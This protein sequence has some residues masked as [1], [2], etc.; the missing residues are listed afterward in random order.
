M[1]DHHRSQRSPGCRTIRG[2][3]V[4]ATAALLATACK[5]GANASQNIP[6]SDGTTVPAAGSC[7][8]SGTATEPTPDPHCTPG[9]TN[10]AVTPITIMQTICKSGW[11]S[12]IRPPTSYT[13]R[14]KQ[15]QIAAY[16]YTDTD[17]QHYEE[18]HLISLELGGAP[19][20]PR[21]L[22]PE[23]GASPNRKDKI[24]NA[25]H[26]AV[27]SHRMS[28]ADVQHQI[29]TDWVSLGRQLGALN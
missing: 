25:A 4:L 16:G 23:P 11:T 18:D 20:D 6:Q 15:Q 3:L 17:P 27:C 12:T 19:S 8:R 29:A 13:N 26:D 1:A 24:E 2:A 9:A 28:L 14:L 22:W 10:P 7:H 5:P 21:N